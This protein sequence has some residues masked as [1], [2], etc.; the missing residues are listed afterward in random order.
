MDAAQSKAALDSLK[1]SAASGNFAY[2]VVVV[3]KLD[4][5]VPEGKE[6]YQYEAFGTE[7]GVLPADT[8][9]SREESYRMVT[10]LLQLACGKDQALCFAPIYNVNTT[11]AKLIR[12]LRQAGYARPQEIDHMIREGPEVRIK[13]VH[14]RAP[15]MTLNWNL[16]CQSS[17]R[18]TVV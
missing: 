8:T 4:D 7:E 15:L 9:F 11:E 13:V 1:S 3:G 12:G 2:T 18:L 5:S 16:E 14:K 10:E 17:Y 6:Y